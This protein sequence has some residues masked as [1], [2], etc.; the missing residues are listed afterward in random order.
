MQNERVPSVIDKNKF[1]LRMLIFLNIDL[2][3]TKV[4]RIKI[5]PINQIELLANKI[6][7]MI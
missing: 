1:V 2:I 7:G 6:L 4:Q 5:K 3:N